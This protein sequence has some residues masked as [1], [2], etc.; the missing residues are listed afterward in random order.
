MKITWTLFLVAIASVTLLSELV[1]GSDQK[2]MHVHRG[3]LAP[4]DGKLIAFPL[5]THQEQTLSDGKPVRTVLY[6]FV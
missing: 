4:Y 2:K 1:R 3:T 6:G 5:S